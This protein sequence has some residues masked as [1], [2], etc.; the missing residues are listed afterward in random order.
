MG[1]GKQM[2]D[3]ENSAVTEQIV[4]EEKPSEE[5]EVLTKDSVLEMLKAR[6][7]EINKTWQSRF[8][9]LVT[10]KK[11]VDTKAMTVEQ[12]LAQIEAERQAERLSFARERARNKAQID[13]NF[14]RAIKL[15]GSDKEEEITAGAEAISNFIQEMKKSFEAEKAKAVQDALVQAG[16]QKKPITGSTTNT[17]TLAEFNKLAPKEQA[18]YMAKGGKLQE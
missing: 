13:E 6:E 11:T 4:T 5:K 8:D 15:Y 2:A 1:G 10:E 14:E 18:D 3:I 9:K 12:R 7:E 16:I 17:L